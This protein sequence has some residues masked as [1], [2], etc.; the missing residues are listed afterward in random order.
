MPTAPYDAVVVVSFGGPE[1]PDD[2]IPFLENVTRGRD[3]PRERLEEVAEQYRSVGGVSPINS[4]NRSLVESLATE[5][6]DHD[7]ELPVYWG[8]RNWA[9]YLTDTVRQMADDGVRRAL[10]FVTSAYSSYSGCRQ[11]LEDIARAR[12]EAGGDAPEIDKIRQFWNHP[13]FVEPFRDQLRHTL[14]QLGEAAPV[15]PAT[16]QLVFS[17]HSL[18]LSMAATSDYVAQLEDAVGLVADAVA[19]DLPRALVWQSRSGPPQVPWLEPDVNDHLRALASEGVAQVVVVPIGFVSD[20]QEVVYDLD[21]RAAATAE[22]LGLR[23][24]RLPTPLHDPRFVAM[25][26]ELIEE[27]LDPTVEP[28]ALGVRGV[29]PA[30]CAEGCCPAPGRPR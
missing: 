28:R 2:V 7:L 12:A 25:V 23:M 15:D 17:A 27:R 10:A 11:Y 19:P 8:N 24:A 1:G 14:A 5:L 21:I 22:E 6:A 4:Q 3:V 26:R 13:G 29:R 20:H 30:P 18:P 16:T 9:P